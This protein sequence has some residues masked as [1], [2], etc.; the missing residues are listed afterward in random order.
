MAIAAG[1]AYELAML[2]GTRWGSGDAK[3]QV[4][5][6]NFWATWCA[7]C[8]AELP[9]LARYAKAHARD[10]LKVIAV[11]I[12]DPPDADA[13]RKALAGVDLPVALY[14][15]SKLPGIE[16]VTPVP[17]TFVLDRQGVLRKTGWTASPYLKLEDLE[18]VVTPLLAE[19]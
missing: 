11:S 15:K 10:G 17:R 18:R 4:V 3:G 2:D 14:R 16:P 5:V 12:D 6:L 8:R 1:P 9:V 13:I 19:K 7:P